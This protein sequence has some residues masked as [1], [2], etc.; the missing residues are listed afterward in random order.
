MK[1]LVYALALL[2][3]IGLV[4][5]KKDSETTPDP[6]PVVTDVATKI[7]GVWKWNKTVTVYDGQTNTNIQNVK[8]TWEFNAQSQVIYRNWYKDLPSD[9]TETEHITSDSYTVNQNKVN[10]GIY[11]DKHSIAQYIRHYTDTVGDTN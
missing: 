3:G 11:T 1:N 8:D 10:T 7:L 4:G 6:T 9:P 5:C 2:L